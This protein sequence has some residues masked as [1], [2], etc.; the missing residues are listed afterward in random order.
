M[1]GTSAIYNGERAFDSKRDYNW[2]GDPASS[3]KISKK[4]LTTNKIGKSEK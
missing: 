4:K 1:V 3:F 2:W